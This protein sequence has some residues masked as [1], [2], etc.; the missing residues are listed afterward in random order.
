MT[1]ANDTPIKTYGS[2]LVK[3]SLN[4]RRDFTYP[5]IIADVKHAIMGADFLDY[6]GLILDFKN[7]RIWDSITN[8]TSTGSVQKFCG[9]IPRVSMVDGAYQTILKEFAE[10]TRPHRYD[11]PVVHSTVHQ[12]LTSGHLPNCKPRRLTPDKLKIAKTEF[13]HMVKLGICRPSS[14]PCASP[15]HL[16]PKANNDWRPCG[17]Y[18]L[19]NA[20]TVPDRY[21]VPH[22]QSF[23]DNLLGKTIFSKLDLVKAYHLIPIAEEDI[24]KTAITT[25]F[26]LFEF[27]R[28][29][30]GLRNASNTF[31]RFMNQVTHGLEFV[32]TYIDDMLIASDSP[33]QHAEHLRTIFGRLRE[34][35]VTIN[36]TK[37]QFGVP[38]L[39][40]LGHLIDRDGV[41]PC[42]EKVE[43]IRSFPRPTTVQQLR[44]FLGMV[45]YYH[46]FIKGLAG[47]VAPL[48]EFLKGN[49][50]RN[51]KIQWEAESDEA[52]SKTK[53]AMANATMLVHPS[54]DKKLQL[55]TDASDWAIGAVLQEVHDDVVKPISF[56]SRKLSPGEAK[57]STYDRELL[58]IFAAIKHFLYFLE[59][60]EF[61]ILT[62]HK[63]LTSVFKSKSV[64]SKIQ[65][66]QLSF[67]ST[68]STDIEHISGSDNTVA[69]ALSRVEINAIESKDL[70]NDIAK[71]QEEDE[72]LKILMAAADTATSIKWDTI[73]LPD[74]KLVCETSTGNLRP[75][76]PQ[77]LRKSLF[78]RIHNLSHPGVRAS[79]KLVGDRYIWPTMNK[80]IGVWVKQ[81]HDCQRAKV[82]KHTRL[83]PEQIPIPKGRFQHIHIDIVGPLPICKGNRY[84]LTTIDRFT[85]W[86]EAFPMPNMEAKTVAE[87]FIAGYI[88]RF[89]APEK[90]SSDQGR[91]F[92]SRLFKCLLDSLGT[93]RI[94]TTPYHP[95]ANGMIERFHRSLK[96][97][98]KTKED[99]NDWLTNLPLIMLSLRACEKQDLQASPA[100][101]VY[102]EKLRLPTDLTQDPAN[103]FDECDDNFVDCLRKR[104]RRITS[105][106]T[107]APSKHATF[108]PDSLMKCD[109]I[110]LRD[111]CA[112]AGIH[113]PY[114]GPFEVLRRS[115]RTVTIV[116]DGKPVTVSFDRVK[117]AAGVEST[118]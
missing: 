34:F 102:G 107:R 116:R 45:N 5:F 69:D 63:P 16:V 87:T 81:C 71:L 75:F 38:E 90:L 72:E 76:V 32:F 80:D 58:A 22:I 85:R 105:A 59:A 15:L 57:R 8:L 94:R 68:Y 78:Q 50:A 61:Q 9:E 26:G 46:R 114:L 21:P 73:K 111:D 1:A 70:N 4:L 91:Q 110:Y 24:H 49:P 23:G 44:R 95:Q 10:V 35:G 17:D 92:E 54:L 33:E 6:F 7:R 67:I 53:D 88:S 64:R 79:R 74:Y 86:P 30:F 98:L 43:A 97:A 112:R 12:I 48:N 82:S 99:P 19:L 20:I 65:E 115:R 109:R 113:P 93:S 13:E 96:T 62:D 83:F 100:E 52:F 18:R 36:V 60:R 42:E 41:K 39:K 27:T 117:P 108:V 66:N 106:P 55:V 118:C 28:M 31:Q 2:R 29:S 103:T 11:R 89:G 56:F 25:P 47:I 77:S 37:C 104:M 101:M 14:S 40:F 51:A 3:I 84:L